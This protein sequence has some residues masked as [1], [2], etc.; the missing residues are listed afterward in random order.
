MHISQLQDVD[1]SMD[2]PMRAS[3]LDRGNAG[4]ISQLG[5]TNNGCGKALGG[6]CGSERQRY[7][8]RRRPHF[9][10]SGERPQPRR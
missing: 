7:R 5:I 8:F 9:R 1:R 10:A 6:S 2:E 4:T 3:G